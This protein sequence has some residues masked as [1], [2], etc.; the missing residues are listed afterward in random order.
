MCTYCGNAMADASDES[1]FEC[2]EKMNC[3]EPPHLDFPPLLFD[4]M[5]SDNRGDFVAI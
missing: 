4:E 1:C 5:V 3:H 2:W